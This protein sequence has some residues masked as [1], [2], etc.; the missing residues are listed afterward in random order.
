MNLVDLIKGHIGGDTL[1]QLASTLGTGTEQTQSVVDAAVPT[2]LAG[3]THVASTPEGAQRLN[4]AME[5]L[6]ERAAGNT[7]ASGGVLG[8]L[9]G[10]GMLSSLSGAFGKFTGLA[11]GEITALLAIIGPSILG[12][13]RGQKENLG[14]DAGGV[15]N[16]LSQQKQNIAAAMPSG[17]SSALSSVPGIGGL[18]GG[19]KSAIGGAARATGDAARYAGSEARSAVNA[20]TPQRSVLPWA[21]GALAILAVALIVWKAMNS[22]TTPVV[23]SPPAVAPGRP[24]ATLGDAI[25]AGAQLPAD[26]LAAATTKINDS[27]KSAT[28][29]FT[30]ITDSASADTAL[31]KL[32]DFSTQLDSIKMLADKQPASGKTQIS[33]LVKPMVEK[34]NPLIDKAMALPGVSDKIS[35]IVTEIRTKLDSLTATPM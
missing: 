31:P 32:H 28:D 19:A 27:M 24:M 10:S 6:D 4:A 16:L 17:L 29:T 9:M 18:L 35:P 33:S 26:P 15:A 23:Q 2:V 22:S 1:S 11:G 30:S 20:I 8:S 13:L 7:S 21:V 3:L 25:P 14:L 5:G 12:V 34:L